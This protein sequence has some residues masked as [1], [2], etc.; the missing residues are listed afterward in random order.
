M[1]LCAPGSVGRLAFLAR[2]PAGWLVVGVVDSRPVEAL[3]HHFLTDLAQL[4]REVP[5]FPLQLFF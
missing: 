2:A 4:A 1:D 5:N 3:P